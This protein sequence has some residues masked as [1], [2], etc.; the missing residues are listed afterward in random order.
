MTV[1]CIWK[2]V[3]CPRALENVEYPFI[4]ITSGLIWPGVV[5]AFRVPA[6]GLEL[7]LKPFNYEL[8]LNWIISTGHQCLELF[9][10]V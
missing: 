10:F 6:M 7:Y 8:M 4:N 2:W 9:Y 1:D 5:V 3:S